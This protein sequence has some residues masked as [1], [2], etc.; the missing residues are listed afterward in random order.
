MYA[1]H[2]HPDVV[3]N[4]KYDYVGRINGVYSAINEP[5]WFYI[6]KVLP[7]SLLPCTPVCLFGVYVSAVSLWQSIV[8]RASGTCGLSLESDGAGSTR[9]PARAGGP[10]HGDAFSHLWVLCWAIV[11]LLILSI[12]K[13]KHDHYVV[14]FL[15]PWAI[16]GSI[17]IVQLHRLIETKT[18][19]PLAASETPT[20]ASL[21]VLLLIGYCFGEAKLAARTDHTIDD[22]AFL[23]R[24]RDEVP[25][26]RPLFID[27][28]LGPPGNLDFFRVQF[29][30]RSDA[31]LLHNLTF[32]RDEK[33]TSPVV[34]VICRSN[35]RAMLDQLGSTQLIDQSR[36]SHEQDKIFGP[37]SL[38]RLTFLPDLKRYPLPD[39]ISSLQAMERAPGPWCGPAKQGR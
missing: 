12:P 14:P 32:L 13:G 9:P 28:K 39:Q 38:F 34:F 18:N 21:M 27:A 25:G 17:G 10:C 2:V 36:L 16:L 6:L 5:W 4:W 29:Y 31:R 26:D 35:D 11:P 22:T 20:L 19:F 30:S 7:G 3:D 1:M 15:A 23:I 37:F 33:I 24:C 8:T